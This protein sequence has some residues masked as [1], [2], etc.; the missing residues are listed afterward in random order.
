MDNNPGKMFIIF[1]DDKT[2][3]YIG[4]KESAG[5]IPVLTIPSLEILRDF[6]SVC[7]EFYSEA[8][9]EKVPLPPVWE[10]AFSEDKD[11]NTARN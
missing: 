1:S 6:N 10:T 9:A 4:R 7:Q 8:V 2:K 5:F 11:G 3:I